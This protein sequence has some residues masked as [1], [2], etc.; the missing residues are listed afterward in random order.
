MKQFLTKAYTKKIDAILVAQVI[1]S[2][3]NEE[4][5]DDSDECASLVSRSDDGEHR[6]ATT[7]LSTGNSMQDRAE[8]A[9]KTPQPTTSTKLSLVTPTLQQSSSDNS[10]VVSSLG[11]SSSKSSTDS[12]SSF[13]RR[14]RLIKPYQH[15]KAGNPEYKT[16]NEM[17]IFNQVESFNS[18][19]S[20]ASNNTFKRQKREEGVAEGFAHYSISDHQKMI[21]IQNC[22][23][24]TSKNERDNSIG[25]DYFSKVEELQIMGTDDDIGIITPDDEKII[26]TSE[27]I[28]AQNL[29]FRDMILRKKVASSQDR[30]TEL[31]QWLRNIEGKSIVDW[32]ELS[33]Y[34][35]EGQHEFLKEMFT[36]TEIDRLHQVMAEYSPGH[37]EACIVN[38]ATTLVDKRIATV[39]RAAVLAAWLCCSKGL[40]DWGEFLFVYGQSN[41]NM[42][43]GSVETS[44]S[45][46]TNQKT[47]EIISKSS[48][49]SSCLM[50][51]PD[52][53]FTAVE[54]CVLNH[55]SGGEAWYSTREDVDLEVQVLQHKRSM[56]VALL[57][58]GI[59]NETDA[60]H[61][62]E[63]L[64]CVAQI[65][66][67]LHLKLMLSMHPVEGLAVLESRGFPPPKV[68]KVV[69][70]LKNTPVSTFL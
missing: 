19:S 30:A 51:A 10:I 63:D 55:V 29:D 59:L 44:N 41:H 7:E 43:T 39:E 16:P 26:T 32:E 68:K 20:D 36:T 6:D 28:E 42:H 60:K 62:A 4:E 46:I 69:E 67:F 25:D 64:Y 1:E 58:N 3:N 61:F 9:A 38:L 49:L 48:R 70:Y 31:V 17:K 2:S 23:E 54:K 37:L 15:H 8:N 5:G 56:A 13:P 35:Y 24:D 34:I 33:W 22:C 40:L 45:D 21:Q 27:A 66:T 50:N 47:R 57:V 11:D 14:L 18:A 65:P 12:S 52:S 53:P